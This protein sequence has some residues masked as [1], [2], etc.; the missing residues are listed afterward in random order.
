MIRAAARPKV[1]LAGPMVFYPNPAATFR[2]MK[3]ICRDH[4]LQGVA[5][6]DNQR[7]LAVR[8]PSKAL[9]RDIVLA[10]IDL[11]NRLDGGLFCLDGFRRAPDMDPG[12]AFEIG[13]MSAQG[14]PMCG[15]TADGR[16]YPTKVADY[17]RRVFGEALHGAG[18]NA[19]GGTSGERRDP[20]EILVHSQGCVQNGMTQIGIERSGG[21]VFADPDW[22]RAFSR[23]A[24]RLG[25]LFSA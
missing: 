19:T 9:I 3:K 1:Y 8:K 4:G 23:A 12:T 22:R 2:A 24:A 15:W 13:Y 5:P 10:D 17:F 21:K 14:K 25:A 18:A 6:T 11:M 16:A 20:D 7:G